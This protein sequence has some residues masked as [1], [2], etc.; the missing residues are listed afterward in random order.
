MIQKKVCKFEIYYWII[1]NDRI[2]FVIPRL[3]LEFYGYS[4][5]TLSRERT[6]LQIGSAATPNGVGR[7][8]AAAVQVQHPDTS[9]R[10]AAPV[11]TG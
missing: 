5:L 11:A 3:S 8:R 4:A 6:C 1:Y 10:R 2:D 7:V 9:T